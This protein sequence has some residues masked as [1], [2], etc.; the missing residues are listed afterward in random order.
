MSSLELKGLS[1][2]EKDLVRVI[3]KKYPNEAKKFMRKQINDVKK[4]AAND[5]PVDKGNLKKAWKTSTKGKKNASANFIE[6]T[7]TNDEPHS[8]LIESGHIISNQHGEYGF[9][10]GV[11]MLEK[12]VTKKN[13]E[14]DN[15]LNK[16]INK[17][18][19]EL[20]L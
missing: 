9:Q 5:T 12:A 1:S 2:F 10:E 11:H 8:H 19:V 6:S 16:F 13:A 20:K 18:L 15:E 17:A 3:E 7:I 14:F 4:Q